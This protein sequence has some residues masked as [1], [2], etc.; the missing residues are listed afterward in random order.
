MGLN[1]GLWT[2]QQTD[3]R[4]TAEIR[5][6]RTAEGYRQ[7]DKNRNEDNKERITSGM[8]LQE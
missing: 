1:A 7:T 8:L 2:E 5:I 6:L 4:E 3:R